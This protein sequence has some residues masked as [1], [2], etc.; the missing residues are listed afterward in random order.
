MISLAFLCG[1]TVK[2]VAN[3]SKLINNAPIVVS[4]ASKNI[5]AL[6]VEND[7]R[8]TEKFIQNLIMQLIAL[9]SYSDLKLVFLLKG[10]KNIKWEHMKT[11]P[12]IWDDQK[13]IRFWAEDYEDMKEISRYLEI[14][15]NNR[16]RYGEKFDYRAFAPYYLIITDNYKQIEN[17]RIITEILG[18]KVNLGFGIFCVTDNLIHLPNECQ[19]FINIK[20]N[21]G[22]IF[23]NQITETTQNEFY[24]DNS[25]TFFFENIGQVLSNIPIKENTTSKF[26]LPENYTFLEMYDAGKIEQLNILQRWRMNDSTKSLQAP[27]GIDITG[28]QVVLDIHEKAH[29]PHGLIAGSTGSGKSELIITYILSLAINYHPNDVEIIL[30]DYK[31]GGL[32]GAF[33]KGNIK[34]PHLVGTITNIDKVGLNRSLVSIQ[35]ELRRRQI[36]FNEAREQT[37][38]GTID[39]Y[40]YQ[41]L[42]HD[43]Y[44]KEPI[45]HLLII[46]DEFAELKQQQPDFMDEL[47][48]VAR[49]GR[50]LGVHLILATQKPAGIVNDQIRSNSRFGICLKVQDRQD[51][52]DVIKRP[53]AAELKSAGQFY[54][55]VGNDEYFTLGLAAWSGAKYEPAEIIKKNV[56][57]SMKFVSDTGSIIKRIDNSKKIQTKKQGEQLTNIVKYIYELGRNENIKLKPLWLES[58]PEIIFLKD[59][60]KKYNVEKR[61]NEIIPVIG[62][63]D[64]PYNQRQGVVE[65]NFSKQGNM[66]IYGN[67]ESGKETL[68][69][70][71][72][73]DL[74]TTYAV[75]EVQMYLLDFGS[76]TL[77]IFKD[78]PHVGDVVLSTDA[79]KLTRLFEM[80]QREMKERTQ[81]LS[82]YGGDIGLYTKSTNKE[83]PQIIVIINNYEG[84]LEN[85]GE[86][87]DDALLTLCRDGIKYGIIFILSVSA[88]NSVRYR[89]LQ[90]FRQKI[91]LQLNNE[92]DYMNILE[93]VKRQRPSHIF[94][95]GLIKYNDIYE[96]QTARICKPEIWNAYVREEIEKLKQIYSER[97]TKI[98][99]LPKQI[100]INDIKEY[101]TKLDKLPVGIYKKNL[102]LATY[103]FKNNFINIISA[104]S[105]DVAAE[106]VSHI[107]EEITLLNNVEVAI[108]DLEEII[109]KNTKDIKEEYQNYLINLQNKSKYSICIIIGLDKFLSTIQRD[110]NQDLKA[111]EATKKVSFIIVDSVFKLKNHEYEEWYKNYVSKDKGIWVGNGISDQYLIHLN[112]S[113]RN[114]INNCGNSFGYI[115]NQEEATMI[116]LLGMKDTGDEN[117]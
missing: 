110:I 103:N 44:V 9:H 61:Q 17:L 84:F 106:Y 48:S 113:N 28:N 80:L 88:Y 107:Y 14:E 4:L 67:A 58:L 2:V 26:S 8:T 86:K 3:K 89:L 114:V 47:I 62:E 53:D 82:N 57:T 45:P 96:F 90:N 40:K 66:I 76:E 50:S 25:F 64:D 37:D 52:I 77:K 11:I 33:K 41:K 30:I 69:T 55:Q 116:K 46:C 112:S 24:F 108:F 100:E 27:I 56:D 68:I 15:F 42:Y 36:K 87:F 111:L 85:Y 83:M 71:M 5:S 19:L 97:A 39:I 81:L 59:I 1:L 94:G 6:I 104:K 16:K 20:G 34:I 21:N 29:G 22:K 49:I 32:A 18:S 115:I 117:G 101:I 98:P 75:K 105:I 38:E 73:F 102:S 99:V 12:H 70:T 7:D 92:D 35:S 51:S 65:L 93:G 63:Y 91:A 54:M 78:A 31:G 23:E 74:I 43:G 109:M 79:E 95:R 60:K 10:N 13:Q 72:I